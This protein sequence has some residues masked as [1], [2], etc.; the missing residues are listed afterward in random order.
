ML[1]NKRHLLTLETRTETPDTFG[2]AALS[3]T[4]LAQAWASIE[5]VSAKERFAAQQVKADVS[6]RIKIRF[7]ASYATLT[8]ADRIV[9]GT[10][11]FDIITPP[12]DR[13]G[14]SRE[15]EILV[16]ERL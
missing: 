7:A 16:L 12:M 13:E 11:I 9:Y 2:D 8:P 10:R 14:M 5:S 15:L 1:S 3:Y 6:H 4:E